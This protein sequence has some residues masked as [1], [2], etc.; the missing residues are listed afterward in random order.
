MSYNFTMDNLNEFMNLSSRKDCSI[1]FPKN[2]GQIICEK[3]IITNDILLFKTQTLS[4]ENIAI[5]QISK[6]EGLTIN[7]CIDGKIKYK[8]NILKK[9]ASFKKND[10]YIRYLSDCDSTIILDKNQ[11]ARSLG[12]VIRND[13]LE[14]NIWNAISYKKEDF[15][16]SSLDFIFKNENSKNIKLAK[17]L[18]YSPFH[19]GNLHNI[20]IQSK[21]LEIIYNELNDI[22]RCFCV[23]K[24]SCEK[25]KLSKED[26]DSL[27]KARDIILLT[28]DFPDLATLARKVALNEFKLKFGFKKIFNTTPG[29]MIL[30]HKMI[31]AKQLL[32][33]SEFSIKEISTFVGYKYQQS[34]T[35]AFFQFFKVL[36]KD[37]MK[38]RKYYF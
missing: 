37:V 28:H 26:I 31:H 13:F 6:I 7:L 38:T 15:I 21:V 36:P 3:E 11:H 2:I 32:E 24:Y 19:N 25:V 33:T 1:I 22:N 27:Y 4:N 12:I 23:D 34:F 20:Y 18:F 8:D 9:T 5:S 17:E 35:N 29:N 30:E 10:T 14:D 16:K